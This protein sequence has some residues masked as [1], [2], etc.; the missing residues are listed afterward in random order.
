MSKSLAITQNLVLLIAVCIVFVS[1]ITSAKAGSTSSSGVTP[2]SSD[3][4]PGSADTIRRNYFLR[5]PAAKEFAPTTLG[6]SDQVV[7]GTSIGTGAMVIPKSGPVCVWPLNP[8]TL[9]S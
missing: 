7:D 6:G 8:L 9:M 2:G 5:Y 1:S 3:I 4:N